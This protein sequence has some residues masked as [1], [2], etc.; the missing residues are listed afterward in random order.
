L[1]TLGIA[2]AGSVPLTISQAW[3]CPRFHN[4]GC[5]RHSSSKLG[6][7]LVFTKFAQ[8]LEFIRLRWQ[9]PSPFLYAGQVFG[10]PSSVGTGL[11]FGSV[12]VSLRRT[13]FLSFP[14]YPGWVN[15]VVDVVC[16]W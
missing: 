1:A 2:Q 8:N 11:F 16:G 9:V 12:S 15:K 13:S 7:A 10:L 4:F 3:L 5:T 14:V 6:S